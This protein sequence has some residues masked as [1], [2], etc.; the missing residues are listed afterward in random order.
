MRILAALHGD[1]APASERLEALA[2]EHEL[3][4]TADSAVARSVGLALRN[5]LPDRDVVTVPIH[6]V[7]SDE[8]PALVG[9]GLARAVQPRAI[10]ELRSLRALIEAGSVV[11]CDLGAGALAVDG[12]GEMRAVAASVD[13]DLSAELLARRLDAELLKLGAAPDPDG[14]GEGATPLPPEPTLRSEPMAPPLA[15]CEETITIVLADDH[16]VVRGALRALLEGQE[17]FE[18]VGEAADIASTRAA[19]LEH[20]PRVLI[21]DVNMPDG[22]AVDALADLREG[23]PGTEVVLLTMERDLTLARRA[24]EDGARGYLFKDAAHLELIDAVRHAAAGRDYVPAAIANGLRKGREA[25]ER[26]LLSP[27]E[28]EVL[29]LLALGHTNREIA[30]SLELSVRTVETHR[31]H[32]QQ[33]LGLSSRPDLTRYALAHGLVD[34]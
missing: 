28:T 20:R 13:D 21:L 27:R 15:P 16:A 12:V 19:V 24:L 23:S 5:A 18:I 1:P 26:P 10:A 30:D 11:V 2:R 25:E 31:A 4:V 33:K 29:R 6:V 3:I 8:D 32:V 34:S 9:S 22:L 14:D 17:D 7:L